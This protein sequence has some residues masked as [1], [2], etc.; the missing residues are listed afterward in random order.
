ML[1]ALDRLSDI[2]LTDQP[3]NLNRRS[4]TNKPEINQAV[5]ALAEQLGR[6]LTGSNGYDYNGNGVDQK[7]QNLKTL[8]YHAARPVSQENLPR[9]DLKTDEVL[10]WWDEAFYAIPMTEVVK[11]DIQLCD[12]LLN[13]AARTE[14][15]Y[16]IDH[17]LGDESEEWQPAELARIE[18]MEKLEQDLSSTY[19][20]LAA[21]SLEEALTHYFEPKLVKTMI[22]GISTEEVARLENWVAYTRRTKG[23]KNPAG[24]LRSRIENG[25]MP[26]VFEV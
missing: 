15:Y 24:F 19:Q 7:K 18:A 9:C 11:H 22:T 8:P 17:A 20:R 25:E 21:F 12:G 23:L 4:E 13:N 6:V 26:P 5:D 14:C 10:V 3:L 16:S 1:D 2:S